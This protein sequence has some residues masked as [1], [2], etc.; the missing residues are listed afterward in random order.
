MSIIQ[1]NTSL[2]VAIDSDISGNI[3]LKTGNLTMLTADTSATKILNRMSIPYGNTN[4]RSV[5]PE[6]GELRFNTDTSSIEGYDGIS[7]VN[8]K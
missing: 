7:W 2:R 8:L 4:S 5:S 3:V 1:S 6:Q